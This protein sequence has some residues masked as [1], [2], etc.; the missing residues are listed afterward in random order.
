MEN[1]NLEIQK[2]NTFAMMYKLRSINEQLAKQSQITY[3]KLYH[4]IRGKLIDFKKFSYLIDIYDDIARE[5]VVQKSAQCGIS[6]YLISEAF[7]LS[8]TK[9]IKGLYCFPA[10]GQLNAFSHDRV[11]AVINESPHLKNIVGDVDNVSLKKIGN[12]YI[13]FRG[14]QQMQQIISID[15]DYLMLDEVDIM[16]SDN[17]DV[18]NRRLGGSLHKIKRAVSTP[19]HPEHGINAMFKRGTMAE[20]FIRCDCCGHWQYLDFFKNIDMDK[21]ICVCKKCKKEIDRLKPGTWVRKFKDRDIH[22]YHI[23][24]LFSARTSIKELIDD[25]KKTEKRRFFYNFDLGLPYETKGSKLTKDNLDT[26]VNKSNYEISYNGYRCCMGVDVGTRINIIIT[27]NNSGRPKVIYAGTVKTFEELDRFMKVYNI[28][29][30]VIDGLPETR[31]SKKFAKRFSGRVFLAYYPNMEKDT[32]FKKDKRDDVGVVNINRTLSLDYMFDD[33]FMQKISLPKDIVLVEDF[34]TQMLS[35]TRIM[36]KDKSGNQVA[37]YI[38]KDAD[39][40]AHARNYCRVAE[41]LSGEYGEGSRFIFP[42]AKR[43]RR[44]SGGNKRIII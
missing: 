4:P 34:Y 6:E 15:A 33:F 21:A 11:Q 35:L 20:W 22:S 23:S 31:E 44:F 18:V 40:Y 7:F 26:I 12:T 2:Q 37:R 5:I 24:K 9:R 17:I 28:I 3:A 1:I 39:H 36:E 27:E 29:M 16:K 14:M 13:Y 32:Y 25:Y 8:E 41:V 10:Q 19:T 38:D 30:C 42:M 43:D